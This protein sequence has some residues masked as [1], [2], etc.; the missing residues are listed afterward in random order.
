M[1]SFILVFG[2][3]LKRIIGPRRIGDILQIITVGFYRLGEGKV[4]DCP[5]GLEPPAGARN[6]RKATVII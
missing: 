3:S 4:N 5:A 6:R 2:T 1:F